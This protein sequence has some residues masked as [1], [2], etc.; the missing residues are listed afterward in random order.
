MRRVFRRRLRARALVWLWRNARAVLL[1]RD[2]VATA[3]GR[4][5]SRKPFDRRYRDEIRQTLKGMAGGVERCMYC[6]DSAGYAIEHFWPKS[7]FPERAFCWENLLLACDDCNNRYKQAKFPLDKQGEPLLIDPTAE[8]P[9][10][11]LELRPREGLLFARNGS[12]KGQTT[13]G[14]LDLNRPRLRDTRKHAWAIVEELIINYDQHRAE[15]RHARAEVCMR[16]LGEYMLPGILDALLHAAER[17]D[18]EKHIDPA[19]LAA[20]RRRAEDLRALLAPR[21]GSRLTS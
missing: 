11:H 10:L 6:S 7:R 18:A 17:G 2:R 19:C 1:A 4:W 15:G 13:I 20:I 21:D 3:A 12:A 8:D 14:Y 9:W 16:S 5:S